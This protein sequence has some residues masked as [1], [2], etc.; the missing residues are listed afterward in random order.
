[1]QPPSLVAYSSEDDDDDQP[2][3]PKRRKLPPLPASLLPQVPIDDPSKHQGRTRT[4]PHVEGQFAAYIYVSLFVDPNSRLY[5]LIDDILRD[6]RKTV[7]SLCEI[8]LQDGG[9]ELHVSLSRPT[10][11]RAHQREH[12]KRAV[13]AVAKQ[14]SPFTASFAALSD[15]T[16][17]ERT[18]TFITMEV[19]AGHAEL[20]AMADALTP[21]LKSIRQKEFYTDPRFHASIAW[22]LLDS[23][24]P[25]PPPASSPPLNLQSP[26]SSQTPPSHSTPPPLA[27]PPPLQPTFST[28][29]HLP[30][31]LIPSLNASHAPTLS[32]P[33]IG[34]FHVDTVNVKIGKQIFS[35]GLSGAPLE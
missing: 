32:S 8:A 9:K 34:S 29:P 4:T 31:S 17:D 11:L 16:N 10:Y 26:S 19:G 1:M 21:T 35:W 12:L 25:S 24:S 28:I 7:P 33:S 23:P 3:P 2:P 13:K 30:P 20:R 27:I 5:A 6:A 22:A 18:R 15:L 14:Y